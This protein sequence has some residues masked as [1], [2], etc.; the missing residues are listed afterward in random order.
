MCY[1]STNPYLVSQNIPVSTKT[2]LILMML[3]FSHK[4]LAFFCINSTLTRS[5]SVKALLEI[6]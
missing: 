6:F 3:A 4:N 1:V 5:N 2:L